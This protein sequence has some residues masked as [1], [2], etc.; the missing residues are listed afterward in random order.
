MPPSEIGKSFLDESY[1][2]VMA[3]KE[4]VDDG[5][6]HYKIPAGCTD[7]EMRQS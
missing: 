2:Q 7:R 1:P 6:E 4:S 3:E 5:A